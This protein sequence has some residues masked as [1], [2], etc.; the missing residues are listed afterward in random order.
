MVG[1]K[2]FIWPIQALWYISKERA[3]VWDF[4]LTTGS[5]ISKQCQVKIPRTQDILDSLWCAVLVYHTRYV[6]DLHQGYIHKNWRKF[7]AF[8][9]PWSLYKWLRISFGLKK[10]PLCLIS[11][12]LTRYYLC[13]V[14]RRYLNLWTD[15]W[16]KCKKCRK[17]FVMVERK[18]N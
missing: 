6:K 9:T 13:N 18:W 15:F 17:I 7:T 11:S 12:R 2:N 14:F 8:S 1:L 10:F 3:S 5:L 4:V 16:E